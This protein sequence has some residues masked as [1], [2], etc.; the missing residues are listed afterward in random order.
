MLTYNPP[1]G[2]RKTST[3]RKIGQVYYDIGLL[4]S[5]E[6]VETSATDLVGQYVGQTG[7]K[8]R[9]VLERGLSKVLFIDEVYRLAEG[10]FAKEAIDKI[11]DSITKP[12]FTQRLIIAL[13]GYNADINRLMSI[14]PG[15][16]SRFPESLQFDPLSSADCVKLVCELLL[17]EKG[18]ILVKSQ[19]QFD[20]VCLKSPNIN[21]MKEMLQRFDRLSKTASWANT[22]DVGTLTKTIFGKL[23]QSFHG[24]K[25]VLSEDMVLQAF[26]SMILERSSREV[27]PQKTPSTT[28]QTSD[29]IDLALRTQSLSNLATTL[30]SQGSVNED[31]ASSKKL[32]TMGPETDRFTTT[33]TRDVGVTDDE[34]C[35][36][37][38]DKL[39]A[40][41]KEKEYSCLNDEEEQQKKKILKLKEEGEKA[42]RE[43]EDARGKADED[44]KRRHEQDR[45]Q[46]ELERRRQERFMEKL[47][48]QQEALAEARRKEQANQTKL[49]TMGVCVM[50]YRWIK[51]NGGYRCAGGSHWGR[52][53]SLEV[54]D[55]VILKHEK[56][57]YF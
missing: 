11:V 9:Q 32:D 43:L 29:K 39:L 8:T 19:A 53:R 22:R 50:E 44:A 23:L 26:D 40:N 57:I 5:S 13:A 24:K 52:M 3:A 27:Y 47:H 36:L 28:I 56:I 46:H 21:F 20:L 48:R 31:V 7:P 42:A 25:L 45:L 33:T 54:P 51:Q 55:L 15:L 1:L 49:K 41:A 37:E 6:V 18:K 17:K 4:A 35:Q 2:T 14:N 16:T 34:W 38:N 10:H 30:K 12:R